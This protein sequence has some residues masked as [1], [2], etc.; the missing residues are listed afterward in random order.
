MWLQKAS[1]CAALIFAFII[2]QAAIHVGGCY[3][4]V[5]SLFVASCTS[6]APQLFVFP[7]L[8]AMN[9]IGFFNSKS[10]K[11]QQTSFIPR[12]NSNWLRDHG[13]VKRNLVKTISCLPNVLTSESTTLSSF[14]LKLLYYFECYSCWLSWKWMC[15]QARKVDASSACT[16]SSGGGS[17]AGSS[18]EHFSL[19]FS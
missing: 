8:S 12:K 11:S 2:G 18:V 7:C 14:V 3:G 17:G 16:H 15:W 9:Y 10:R 6:K 19:F 1:H 13:V 5:Y 4:I